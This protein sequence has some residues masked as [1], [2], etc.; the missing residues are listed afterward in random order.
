VS[1]TSEA[2]KEWRVRIR[3]RVV[4]SLGGKCCICGYARCARSLA[5]HH[6]E[7]HQKSFSIG[8]ATKSCMAWV[9][10][11]VELRKCV[12]LCHN[13][14]GEVHDGLVTIPVNA[15]RFD[16]SYVNSPRK[17]Q[18]VTIRHGTHVAYAYH[19]C[20]CDVCRTANTERCKRWRRSKSVPVP[21]LV[22]GPSC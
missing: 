1:Y 12:L 5:A 15:P 13:C 7:E 8:E 9:K 18:Q 3:E 21:Q 6:L 20:R 2:V 11:V 17:R 16:E 22:R 10:L 14:H 19:K 4:I